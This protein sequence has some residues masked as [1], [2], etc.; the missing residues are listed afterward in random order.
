MGIRQFDFLYD[1]ILL[2]SISKVLVNDSYISIYSLKNIL[3]PDVGMPQ[4][5][6]NRYFKQLINGVVSTCIIVAV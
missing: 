5:D 3:E 2:K 4:Q 1:K 6:A